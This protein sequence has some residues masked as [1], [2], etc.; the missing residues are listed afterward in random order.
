MILLSK[1]QKLDFG[2]HKGKTISYVAYKYP[3]YLLFM[4]RE[5]IIDTTFATTEMKRWLE[6][7]IRQAE[8]ADVEEKSELYS[9]L[10]GFQHEIF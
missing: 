5:K 4:D 3:D 9:E 7:M 1:D 8:L 6:G 10:E 2:K